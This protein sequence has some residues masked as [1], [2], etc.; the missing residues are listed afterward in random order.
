MEGNEP[1]PFSKSSIITTLQTSNLQQPLNYRGITVTYIA[2]KVYNS[3]LLNRISKHL[4]L[5]LRR[6]TYDFLMGRSA[7]PQIL[8]LRR[9]IE[10]IKIANRQTSVVSADFSKAFYSVNRDAMLH[11]LHLYGS[12]E[13]ITERVKTFM[14]TQQQL[15]MVLVVLLNHPKL[16]QV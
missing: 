9:I 8:V 6:S 1:A 7:V 12:P 14:K 10:K 2:S 16:Q 15:L 11:I 3:L 4:E 13:K 5:I